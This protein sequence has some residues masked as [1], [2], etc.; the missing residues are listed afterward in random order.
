MGS[1]V[2]TM[3]ARHSL[4][5]ALVL[6]LVLIL[7]DTEG[8]VRVTGKR[9]QLNAK[10]IESVLGHS[11][12]E[13]KI[14]N[15]IEL[16]KMVAIRRQVEVEAQSPDNREGNQIE[17]AAFHPNTDA[18]N[19]NLSIPDVISA[20]IGQDSSVK[21]KRKPDENTDQMG[22]HLNPTD[23]SNADKIKNENPKRGK[24]DRDP[25]EDD[26]V[27]N[28][29]QGRNMIILPD[30]KWPRGEIPYVIASGFNSKERATI[31]KAVL[32]FERNTCIRVRPLTQYDDANDGYVKIIK[33][34]GCFS[35]VGRQPSPGQELSIGH[36]CQ[37]P[38]I[39]VH[40]FMHALGFWHEQSRPD[41]DDYV[42]I[43]YDNI[44]YG[45]ESNFE[46]Y[47]EDKVQVL[48]TR[49]DVGSVMHYGP[50]AF[51]IDRKKPTI[52][53]RQQTSKEMGQ[54]KGLSPEDINKINKLYKCEDVTVPPTPGTCTD[55]NKYC[56]DWA[57]NGE[58]DKNPLYMKIHCAKSCNT[59]S[60]GSC[61]DLNKNC[62]A[63]AETGECTK[64]A[65][66]MSLYCQQS[67]GLCEGGTNVS[68][69][70]LH[71]YCVAWADDGECEKNPDYMH[72]YCRKAC[73]LC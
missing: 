31:A 26:I 12:S 15:L 39:I 41:R 10:K 61:Q 63:W 73:K 46:K 14:K 49:Y 72:V 22:E 53:A 1:A 65:S 59:C 7:T 58:C 66:Y 3:A 62:E 43:N 45:R 30:Q 36:G 64:T 42:W 48:G 19:H 40:E 47:T 27:Y 18:R 17:K 70:N 6:T 28:D 24:G 69:H 16:L 54:R 21:R 32:E 29:R 67:C 68:C 37:V 23:F 60:D 9:M 56:K 5:P 44:K 4:L 34:D 35:S 55:R 20:V 50:Y 51:A 8:R 38:G 33:G 2:N 57:S 11:E 71:R 13:F 52:I 25:T